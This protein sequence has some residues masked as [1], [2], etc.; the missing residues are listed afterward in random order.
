MPRMVNFESGWLDRQ[1][2]SASQRA[3]EL[4]QWLTRSNNRP[5]ALSSVSQP[6]DQSPNNNNQNDHS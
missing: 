3:S 4:P 1:L 2:D 6:S 5:S